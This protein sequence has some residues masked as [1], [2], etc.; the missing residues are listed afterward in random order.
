M[1]VIN[2][3]EI[4]ESGVRFIV[5]EV[6]LESLTNISNNINAI[7]KEIANKINNGIIINFKFLEIDFLF[8][9][10]SKDIFLEVRK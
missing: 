2:K 3:M 4:I 7:N 5:D 10:L 9:K 1:H 6:E 8:G